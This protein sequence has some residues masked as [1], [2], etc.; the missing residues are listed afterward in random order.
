MNEGVTQNDV[1]YRKVDELQHVGT[2][3]DLLSDDQLLLVKNDSAKRTSLGTIMDKMLEQITV[4][5]YTINASPRQMFDIQGGITI[6]M[7]TGILV[8]SSDIIGRL[9]PG[10]LISVSLTGV[11]NNV[12]TGSGWYLELTLSQNNQSSAYPIYTSDGV[13]LC[14]GA[15]QYPLK[16]G[17]FNLVF[18]SDVQFDDDT[19]LTGWFIPDKIHNHD[20]RYYLTSEI[21]EKVNKINT[22]VI[23]TT[24][25]G[26]GAKNI[27]SARKNLGINPWVVVGK[28]DTSIITNSG[29]Y[30]VLGI[31]C[32]T[33]KSCCVKMRISSPDNVNFSF[34]PVEI[35]IIIK[36]SDTSKSTPIVYCNTGVDYYGI[37]SKMYLAY[38]A[39]V[40][41]G[42]VELWYKNNSTHNMIKVSVFE[43]STETATG[44]SDGLEYIQFS[45]TN[46]PLDAIDSR[47]TTVKLIS[48]IVTE[49]VVTETSSGLLTAE[50]YTKLLNTASQASLDAH[51]N[52]TANP[53]KVTKA[54]VGLGKVDNTADVNKS[55][56]YAVGATNDSA[57]QN[58]N[59]TYIKG[60]SVSGQTVTATRGDNTTFTITTQDKNVTN[61]LATT[62]KAYLTGTTTATTNT[63]TQ[64]FDTGV[65]LDTTAGSLVAGTVRATTFTGALSGNASSASKLQTART[66]AL[67][68]S[69]TGSGTFDGSGNLSIATTTNHTHS[70]AGSA[71]VGGPATKA[72]ND[73]LG[74]QIDST[75]IKNLS[76]SGQTLTA[77]KGDDSTFT[78]TTQDKNVT[79]TLNTTTK[80]YLTGTTSATTNTGTQV[81]DTGVYLDTTAGSLVAGTVKA[82]TFTGALS[83]NASTATKATQDSAG[84]QITTTYIK[85]L[86]VA[87]TKI[88]ITK[89]DGSTSTIYTQD[90]NTD[91]KVTN[92]L[93][94]TT[95]AYVTGTTSATTNTGTQVFDTGVYLDTTAGK[96]VAT[97]F[98]GSLSGNASTASKLAT[99]RT[100]ALTG[101]VTGSGTFDGSGNLSIATTLTGDLPGNASTATK[102]T[103]DSAGQQITTTYIKGLSASGTTLTITKGDGSTSTITTQDTNTDTKVTQLA[104]TTTNYRPLMMGY[105]NSTD[106]STLAASVTNITHVSTNIY[107]Q[108]STGTIF[109]TTFKGALSGNA[110]TATKATQDS[111]GQQINTTY[112]KGLSVSGT[113]LT[114]TKGDGSTSTITT[115]DTNTDTKVT[116]T[117][118]TTTKAYITGTTSATTNT[119]TQVF[120]TGVYLDTT[121]GGLNATS[122]KV[123]EKVTMIYDSTEECLS[124][125]FV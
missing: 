66:I 121:A 59:T 97:T 36:R 74:Q 19:T 103:Q 9:T 38:N 91:T 34:I 98:S 14:V 48:D 90:T 64:V 82:T 47:L 118:A 65:Y 119:G 28:N 76:I 7:S 39:S 18:L 27:V 62:T 114:I 96:L 50:G 23:P 86:S 55:V 100:I 108:P 95:K 110:S 72:I 78:L 54:Q 123:A 101:S 10:L 122:Y 4:P 6:T 20:D 77:T 88:T 43:C 113:K 2:K 13:Q 112:I 26:T 8:A 75:Y 124:F 30:K 52:D 67:T 17:V 53:H 41:T 63:G 81:F 92:T 57:G 21:D 60:L 83:G 109:A 85:G 89:G 37:L 104:T 94:T 99:A 71:S 5:Q 105:T 79:N 70:Y 102:A 33:L 40:A 61:T 51:M 44:D 120:D 45:T 32:D 115:Q 11:L 107:A 22:T 87:G 116:N 15:D 84:Q 29:Y 12:Q 117:L 58:I 111:A 25:G 24:R 69:V 46:T 16:N 68:G 80:A 35:S 49:R 56:K 93:A 106:V 73:N 31:E 1:Y 42:N 125:A 3:E